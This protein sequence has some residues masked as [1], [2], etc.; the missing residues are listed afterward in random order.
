MSLRTLKYYKKEEYNIGDFKF[1]ISMKRRVQRGNNNPNNKGKIVY[2][3]VDFYKKRLAFWEDLKPIQAVATSDGG[4]AIGKNIKNACC[5]IPYD[6]RINSTDFYVEY[7]GFL[8]EID[9]MQNVQNESRY[10]KLYLIE[11]GSEDKVSSYR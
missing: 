8:Y 4:V 7:K 2:E 1:A 6:Y 9:S 3:F 5:V 11:K 10:L